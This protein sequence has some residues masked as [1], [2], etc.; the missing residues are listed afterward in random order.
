MEEEDDEGPALLM[1][2]VC[3]LQE[4]EA[5]AQGKQLDLHEP[6]AQVL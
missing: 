5:E 2:Q 6:R 1:A 3:A 4:V